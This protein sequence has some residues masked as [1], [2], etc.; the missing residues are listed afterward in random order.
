MY[1]TYIN[2]ITVTVIVSTPVCINT[3][4]VQKSKDV[5]KKRS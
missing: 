4:F 5:K 1:S 3:H 2:P